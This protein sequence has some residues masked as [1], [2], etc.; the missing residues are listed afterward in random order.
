MWKHI[1]EA[2]AEAIEYMRGRQDG[3]ISSLK[4]RWDKFNRVGMDGIEW[5]N[6]ITFSGM[7]GSGKTL[8]LSELETSLFDLNKAQRFT[9]LSN[10]YEM[11]AR[12]LVIRK[13]S[14]R[15][16][17]SY[18]HLLS[19][20]GVR[21]EEGLLKMAEEYVKEVLGKYDIF[22][23]DFGMSVKEL[24]NMIF[25]FYEKYKLP[26]V[27]SIDHTILMKKRA[28]QSVNDL[29]YELGE[30]E[31]KVKKLIPIVFINISQLN[32]EIEDKDRREPGSI[33]NYPVKQDI[34]GADAMYQHSDMVIVTHRPSQLYLPVYG[35][36]RIKVEP[37]DIYWHCLK[38][39]SGDPCI[40]RMK[41]DFKHMM[42]NEL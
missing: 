4:T 3:S 18:K 29:L 34:F 31:S 2:G 16:K 17:T 27:L 30:M 38:V 10:N 24:E 8:I 35:P 41:A 14:S 5:G 28:G 32:R 40:L 26:I 1:S 23:V 13:L 36:E 25:E 6:I 33:L 22:Y 19:G 21:L 9:I 11:L 42:I 20:D 39:R 37:D 7:S 12:N 15:F